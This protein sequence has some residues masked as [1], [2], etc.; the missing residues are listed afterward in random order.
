MDKLNQGNES[1]VSEVDES[2]ATKKKT[3]KDYYADPAF[4]ERHLAKLK[5]PVTCECG[6]EVNRNNLHVHKKTRKHEKRMKEIKTDPNLI[7]V[8]N[9][10]QAEYEKTLQKIYEEFHKNKNAF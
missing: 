10:V 8:I 9:K 6:S 1:P 2:M 7:H 4:R 3:F 5:E